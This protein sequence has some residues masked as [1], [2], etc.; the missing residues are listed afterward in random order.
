MMQSQVLAIHVQQRI[1]DLLLILQQA[2][3]LGEGKQ[4][5]EA[6]QS[7]GMLYAQTQQWDQAIASFQQALP[8]LKQ[9]HAE[10]ALLVETYRS[11][12]RALLKT[13]RPQDAILPLE[14]TF[15]LVQQSGNLQD[16][17]EA[18][19]DLGNA[20]TLSGNFQKAL[21]QRQ[22]ALT[23]IQQHGDTYTYRACRVLDDLGTTF[24]QMGH[25]GEAKAHFEQAL[26][27]VREAGIIRL[28]AF[29]L[30]HLGTL[31]AA[32]LKQTGQALGCLD[33]A[34]AIFRHMG[35]RSGEIATEALIQCLKRSPFAGPAASRTY[36]ARENQRMPA[37]DS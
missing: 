30:I 3:Q 22:E 28:E 21:D 33:Q 2:H 14:E 18:R 5:G 15:R 25:L 23:L 8:L 36:Q 17:I 7:V 4:E 6:L 10:D 19:R 35:D 34:L 37:A 29:I 32:H 26:S 31:Y 12:G 1:S 27:T 13:N 9:H 11:L 24:M 20:Y 16:V